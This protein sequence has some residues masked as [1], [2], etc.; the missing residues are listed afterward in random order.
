MDLEN[1][2]QKIADCETAKRAMELL[3]DNL[4][5]EI[6]KIKSTYNSV[7]PGLKANS[8]NITESLYGKKKS[9]IKKDFDKALKE[10]EDSSKKLTNDI[11][12]IKKDI[13]LLKASPA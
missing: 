13:E 5:T 10:L 8:D 4:D 2:K 9:K 1:K 11:A 12:T 7:F 3:K 6:T